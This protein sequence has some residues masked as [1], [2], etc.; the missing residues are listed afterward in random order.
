MIKYLVICVSEG[1]EVLSV[2]PF[3]TEESANSF[4]V[5]D[6]MSVY[7]EIE[8]HETSDIDIYPG[9]AEVVNDQA[10][11]VWSIYPLEIK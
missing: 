11:W 5:K 3:D 8:D 9:Y 7:E 10:D 2:D 6:A 1:G 4:L